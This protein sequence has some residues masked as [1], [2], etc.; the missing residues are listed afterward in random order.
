MS[1]DEQRFLIGHEL[2]HMRGN[3]IRKENILENLISYGGTILSLA[4]AIL[5]YKEITARIYTFGDERAF[6][7]LKASSSVYLIGGCASVLLGTLSKRSLSRS[8]EA[9]ADC[10]AA[11]ELHC[12]LGGC[13]FFLKRI[14][15]SRKFST[16]TG[17]FNTHPTDFKR[18]INLL[19]ISGDTTLYDLVNE[20][21]NKTKEEYMDDI[22]VYLKEHVN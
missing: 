10:Y 17:S 22:L 5:L 11:H 21:D 4:A 2:M 6:E 1:R 9:E 20:T 7:A 12:A 18:F 3:H 13:L 15:K 14:Y 19:L 8:Y 16:E